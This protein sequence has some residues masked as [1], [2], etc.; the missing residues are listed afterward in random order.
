MVVVEVACC[1][2]ERRGV[3][4]LVAAFSGA[5]F[6]SGVVVA[7]WVCCGFQRWQC[8][9]VVVVEAACGDFQR[10]FGA[11]VVFDSDGVRV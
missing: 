4:T 1:K 7:V 10:W 3:K 5:I 6:S 11:N 9:G 8:R 2:C